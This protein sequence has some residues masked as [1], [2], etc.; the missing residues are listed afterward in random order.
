MNPTHERLLATLVEISRLF[1]EWRIGQMIC[2]LTNRAKMPTTQAK[3]AEAIWDIEDEELLA[4]AHE[5][6]ANR[7]RQ[8][9]DPGEPAA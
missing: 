2:N 5:F 6:L 3:A 9:A 1:P 7:R 4:S 8:L